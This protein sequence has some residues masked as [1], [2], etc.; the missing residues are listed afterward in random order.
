MNGHPAPRGAHR[1]FSILH[2][3]VGNI[4]RSV[5]AERLTRL[6]VQNRFGARAN[7]V[8]V[9]SAGTRAQPGAA[10]HPYTAA[11]LRARG[12]D[13]DHY[14]ARRLAVDLIADADVI[15]TATAT[16]RDD[17]LSMAPGA[18]DRTFTLLEF[19]RLAVHLP[20]AGPSE[21]F[22]PRAVVSTAL[23]MRW[24]TTPGTRGSDDI[25]DP[26]RTPE[27]FHQCAAVVADA[28]RRTMA[29]LAPPVAP[30]ERDKSR[31]SPVSG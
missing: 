1:P 31:R 11:A 8:Q 29:A 17:V 2:V 6:E 9:S 24:R 14:A 26:R 19:A 16:E 18:L 21:R 22:Q 25:V 3:C 23:G 7:R 15:L 28:L 5:M 4:C 27:A 30:Y 20:P 12:A 13:P 10:M